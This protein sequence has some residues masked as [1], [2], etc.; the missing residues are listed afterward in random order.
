MKELDVSFTENDFVK[1]RLLKG[2]FPGHII[3]MTK[4]DAVKDSKTGTESYPFNFIIRLS[5]ECAQFAGLEL[6]GDSEEE[7]DADICVGLTTRTRGIWLCPSPKN[8][9]KWKNKEYVDFMEAHGLEFPKSKDGGKVLVEF[10]A[11]DILGKGALYN[12]KLEV[13]KRD[14]NKRE[15]EQR[16]YPK[17]FSATAWESAYEIEVTEEEFMEATGGNVF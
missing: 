15:D 8:E 10:E 12:I 11:T 4:G 9:E 14:F 2:V 6:R 16:T 1:R 3:G 13:D 7:I 17:V 5:P